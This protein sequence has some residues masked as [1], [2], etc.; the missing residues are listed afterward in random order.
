[1]IETRTERPASL[2]DIH[3]IINH[4]LE[5]LPASDPARIRI[6][7]TAGAPKRLLMSTPIHGDL[8]FE[9]TQDKV[10]LEA[11]SRRISLEVPDFALTTEVDG[12]AFLIIFQLKSTSQIRPL[13]R[14]IDS[15][16]R[17]EHPVFFSRAFNALSSIANELPAQSVE[18][19]TASSTDFEVLVNALSAVTID[20]EFDPDPL[21]RAK[22]RGIEHRKRIFEKLGGTLSAEQV[23][24]LIGISRQ[25][26]DKRRGQNQLIGLVQGRRGYAYPA[27]QFEDG[28][29]IDGLKE[30]LDA[31]SGHDPWMQSIFFA[32][33][34]DRLN[35]STP[36]DALRQGKTGAVVRAAEAYGEQGAA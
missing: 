19:L 5:S 20:A 18:E 30:V 27:F 12:K 33:E 36:V 25:A 11:K 24:E 3:R 34:N 17:T 23:S 16:S 21:I 4:W 31:L 1:M 6:S 26:V 10:S 9:V 29:A 13:T 22:L 28:K 32:N 35:G 2:E 7:R 14:V 15:L 8:K